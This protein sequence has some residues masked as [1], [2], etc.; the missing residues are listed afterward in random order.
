MSEF[1]PCGGRILCHSLSTWI[2]STIIIHGIMPIIIH[3]GSSSKYETTKMK[4]TKHWCCGR[5]CAKCFKFNFL[6]KFLIHWDF[7]VYSTVNN[8]FSGTAFHCDATTKCVLNAFLLNSVVTPSAVIISIL[9]LKRG[10][11]SLLPCHK[12]HRKE[13]SQDLNS[14]NSY[15]SHRCTVILVLNKIWAYIYIR[16]TQ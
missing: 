5:N 7:L 1:F 3:Q 11:N 8:G 2:A 16:S 10:K 15:L 12:S 4:F 9:H 6:L 14:W 13:L